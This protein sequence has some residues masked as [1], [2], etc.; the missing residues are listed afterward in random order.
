MAKQ[1]KTNDGQSDDLELINNP[2]DKF[3]KFVFSMLVVVRGYFEQ[4]F[5]KDMA[6]KL[7]LDTLELDSTTYIT[8]E[9]G[10][11]YSDIVWQCQLLK[12]KKKV[13][14]CF[15]FEHKSYV[16]KYPHIQIGDYKQGAYNKQLAAGQPLKVVVPIIVY[17]G[18]RKWIV[19]PFHTYFG[20]VDETFRRFIDPC[21]YYLTNLQDYSDDMIETFNVIFLRKA[22]IAFKH[23]TEKSYLKSHFLDLLFWDYGQDYSKEKLDFV[24]SFYVYLYNLLGGISKEEVNV[25]IEQN[26][27]KAKKE[28]MYNL[29]EEIEK[30]GEIRG[31]KRGIDLGI[32][33]GKKISIYE[34][35]NNGAKIEELSRFFK[36]PNSKI[37]EIIEE[38]RKR[39][40]SKGNS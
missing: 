29:I 14:V 8:P 6:S 38:M 18:K 37:L 23:H 35:Y 3:F 20:K 31:E 17:H 33:L 5:P 16:P 27:N 13:Q 9:L 34:A 36:L 25:M 10:E 39:E 4:L 30:K 22:L 24:K 2:N 32:D 15:I 40:Q 26:N 19:K 12:S 11:F 1:E 21:D 7:N 28:T